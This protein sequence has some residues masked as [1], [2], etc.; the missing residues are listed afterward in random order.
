MYIYIYM[1]RKCA[2]F[3]VASPLNTNRGSWGGLT[4][5]ANP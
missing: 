2:R 3:S 4:L 1:N 5:R